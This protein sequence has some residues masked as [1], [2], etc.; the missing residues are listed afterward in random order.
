[1]KDRIDPLIAE[2]APWLFST[3]PLVRPVRAVLDRM[4]GYEKTIEVG[5]LV[6][7]MSADQIMMVMAEMLAKD[8]EVSGL[9]NLPRQGPALIVANHPTGIADGIMLHHALGRVRRDTYYF[10]NH[11]I[12]RV[13]PQYG[14]MIAPVEWRKEKRS[15]GKT[16]ETMAYTRKAVDEGRLG[17]IFP[18]GRLAKRRGLSLHERPWMASAAMIARKF[19]LPVI[20]VHIRAR[21]SVLF[22]LFD[23]LHPT[24]RDITLFHETLNK[25]RQPYRI[26]L[27][28]A[29]SPKALPAKSEEG[30][31]MLRRATL[32]LGGPK[33]PAVSL[34][35][36][37]RR[38]SWLKA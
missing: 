16:R 14:E 5:T 1:M 18:S 2:R 34:V 21:N 33:A 22:Y 9:E 32:A 4:L 37:T 24:L 17:V 6:K 3:S 31:E 10:A 15:H 28:E 11:D 25:A 38:P 30:I 27:G 35:D 8:L 12:M 23:L 36:A 13:L 20:P 26:T 19:D 7:D 29:I